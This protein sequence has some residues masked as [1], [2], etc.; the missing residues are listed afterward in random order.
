MS[1]RSKKNRRGTM[2]PVASMGDIAF[3]LI[4]F[5]V[6]CSRFQEVQVQQASSID[7]EDIETR[8]KII[9]DV[10]ADGNVYFQG[11][12]TSPGAVEYQIRAMLE[13]AADESSKLVLFRCDRS[14][15]KKDFEPVIEAIAKGGGI[16]AA[17]GDREKEGE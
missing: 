13:N 15:D 8:P 9:V 17:V 16:L 5:F 7:V 10:D 4:I 2:I 11:M 6:L 3:L 12:L 14:V 1:R